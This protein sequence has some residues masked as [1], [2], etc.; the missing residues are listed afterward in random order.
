MQVIQPYLDY[1]SVVDYVD[2]QE[3]ADARYEVDY[4]VRAY[5]GG[6]FSRIV[7][8]SLIHSCTH[9]LVPPSNKDTKI[10]YTTLAGNSESAQTRGVT[11]SATETV[12]SFAASTNRSHGNY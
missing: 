10:L 2:T 5:A 6:G 9:L 1:F 4:L 8:G 7:L 11:E 3:W 12:T